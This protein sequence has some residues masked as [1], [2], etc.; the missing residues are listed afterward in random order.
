[1]AGFS[2]RLIP[3]KQVDFG[4]VLWATRAG[5]AMR[6][7]GREIACQLGRVAVS[8]RRGIDTSNAMCLRNNNNS[9]G[10]AMNN[11]QMSEM[12]RICLDDITHTH[13]T[14]EPIAFGKAQIQMTADNFRLTGEQGQ[15]NAAN[16]RLT[17]ETK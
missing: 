6:K 1:M 2:G 12:T 4:A 15:G 11:K 16:E 8:L 13:A 14:A 3:K 17:S 7:P 9:Q 10:R 5:D